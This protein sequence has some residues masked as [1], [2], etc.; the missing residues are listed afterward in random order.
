M[1]ADVPVSADLFTSPLPC[2]LPARAHR[3]RAGILV[4]S[5]ARR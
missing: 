4:A 5:A 2:Q 1:D 3:Y